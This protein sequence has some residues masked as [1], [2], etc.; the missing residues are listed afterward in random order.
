MS[1]NRLRA[2]SLIPHPI[3]PDIEDTHMTLFSRTVTIKVVSTLMCTSLAACGGGGGGTDSATAAQ[4]VSNIAAPVASAT[5]PTTDNGG[6]ATLAPAQ[7]A[8]ASSTGTS[9]STSTSLPAIEPGASPV[10]VPAAS[11]VSPSVPSSATPSVVPVTEPASAQA[12][13]SGARDGVFGT[14][15]RP[16]A[17]DSLW[18]SRPLNPVFGTFVIP[19][20]S[21]F[22]T[23]ASGAY[24]TGVF[25]AAA[26]DSPMTVVGPG[27][28]AT[29]TVGVADPDS[30]GNRVITLPRWPAGVL[31]AS[32]T[33]GHADIVDPVTNIVHSFWQLK[34]QNGRWT[35]AMYSWSKLGGT[36]WGD[37][38]HYYQ[39]ARAVGIPAS[40]G[41][42]RKHEIKDGLPAYQ[43][44]LAMSLTFNALADG[45]SSPA[46]VFPATA[47]DNTASANTGT[48]PQGSL[49][50]LPPSFDSSA[51]VNPDLKKIVETLK[52]YG[53]Y[54][55]DRNTGTPFVIYVENDAGFNLMPKGWDNTV[56][57]QLDKIRAALRQVTS[58]QAWVDGNGD[59]VSARSAQQPNVN[60][61]SMR[62]GWYRQSGTGTGDYDPITQKFAFGATTTTTVY[63]NANN[64]GLTPVKW[65][66]PEAGTYVN[67]TVRA[68]GGAR[69]RLQVKSGSA[70]T[71]D[72]W[73]LVDGK[74]VRILWPANASV[75][76]IAT[77]GTSGPSTVKG[78]L[79]PST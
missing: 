14:Y 40:A 49:L 29:N 53:A 22:P 30:G 68:T 41:L 65:A 11:T 5:K 43:H 39:G 66:K 37:P 17:A 58:A 26:T 28:T 35:A 57:D 10:T 24:S 74:S 62:G 23:V 79:V 52:L 31:P 21:Y 6:T 32:G 48:I 25:L 47:A 55:V 36:G 56:A 73:D 27:S 13:P 12:T 72:T 16:Y 33:D 59:T 38:S 50:M 20:S 8:P 76:L 63:V 67:F 9:T 4:T 54:V 70:F 60:I 69:L 75:V 34:Q 3:L 45:V 71:H 18:N 7:S 64:T 44:A 1:S 2:K 15:Q 51:I 78:E 61:L 42:I 19:K 77:S 46:Y